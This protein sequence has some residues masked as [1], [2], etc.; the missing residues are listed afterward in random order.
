MFLREA[1]SAVR[2]MG[3]MA[4]AMTVTGGM[5]VALRLFTT[6]FDR[7]LLSSIFILA[8]VLAAGAGAVR[9][10]QIVE[11]ARALL[12]QGYDHR[13]LASAAVLA[14]QELLE[15]RE[16]ARAV[17]GNARRE[18]LGL[19]AIGA[20]KSAA[21]VMVVLGG[22]GP[23]WFQA[24]ALVGAIVLPTVTLRKFWQILR[25]GRGG[26]LR[27]LAGKMGRALL[28]MARIGLGARRAP[29]DVAA[30]E[31]TVVAIG[32]DAV[33]LFRALSAADQHRLADLQPV[34]TRLAADATR[35]HEAGDAPGAREKLA[36]VAAALDTIRLDLLRVRAGALSAMELT[37]QIAIVSRVHD[38]IQDHEE[39]EAQIGRLLRG[40]TPTPA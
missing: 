24:M 9:L 19:V 1:D 13:A 40:H 16:L 32:Q 6:G 22:W 3:V 18:G 15:E 26:W 30:G 27:A 17:P 37:E 29:P 11:A 2:E 39:A 33:G 7:T 35:L 12:R 10:G 23:G 28:G 38:Q 20:L 5:S 14:R 8:M 36:T 25:P 31:L 4:T 34:I 21:M